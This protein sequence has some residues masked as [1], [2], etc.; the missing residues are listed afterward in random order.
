MIYTIAKQKT[1]TPEW[2]NN[3]TLPEQEQGKVIIGFP[4]VAEIAEHAG[5]IE[6]ALLFEFKNHI[7]SISKFQ[8][9]I[10]GKVRDMTVD[11]IIQ[12]PGLVPLFEELRQEYK[13]LTDIDKKK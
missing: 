5:E 12:L 7:K 6:N 8:V 11:D 13:K 3:R 1:Y 4:S 10:D 9:K 2:N